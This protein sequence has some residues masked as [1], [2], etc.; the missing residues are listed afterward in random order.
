MHYSGAGFI[1]ETGKKS[2]ECGV[3]GVEYGSNRNESVSARL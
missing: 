3:I 2:A 1:G